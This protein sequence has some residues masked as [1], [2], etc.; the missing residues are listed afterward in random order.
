MKY[1]PLVI[2]ALCFTCPLGQR[3]QAGHFP[4]PLAAS[5]PSRCP[6]EGVLTFPHPTACDQYYLCANGTLSEQYCPNGLLYAE[7]GSVY[8]FCTYQWNVDC[9]GTRPQAVSTPGC[10]WTFGVFDEEPLKP[11]NI[12]YSHCVWGVPER[13]ECSPPGLLYDDRI[14]GCNWPDLLGCN[15]ENLVGFKCPEEDRSNIYWPFPRYYYN[16]NAIVTCVNGVPRL[17]HC[18]HE[19]A[20]SQ[21]LTCEGVYKDGDRVPR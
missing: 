6:P 14:K 1:L 15:T 4:A 9:K 8:E 7:S 21:A 19:E 18:G 2:F 12:F 17:I 13:K 20:V 10:P 11:C 3:F 16:A 5:A